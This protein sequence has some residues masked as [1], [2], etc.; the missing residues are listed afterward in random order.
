MRESEERENW[1]RREKKLEGGKRGVEEDIYRKWL[2][3]SKK[4]QK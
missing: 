1:E 4:Y 2:V 3:T